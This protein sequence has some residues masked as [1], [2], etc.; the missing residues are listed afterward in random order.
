MSSRPV[1]ATKRAQGQPGLWNES[2]SQKREREGEKERERANKC[3]GK[4]QKQN[5]KSCKTFS[6]LMC[7]ILTI[8]SLYLL[9]FV[10][11]FLKT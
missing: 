3:V 9:G 2:L 8:S 4:M 1:W 6:I 5:R 10:C 11:D 7:S